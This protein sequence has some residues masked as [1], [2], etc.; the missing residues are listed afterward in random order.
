MDGAAAD[1]PL[2]LAER[3]LGE[4]VGGLENDLTTT[5]EARR[6]SVLPAFLQQFNKV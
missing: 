2:N 1:E 5:L 6:R 3:A 4:T